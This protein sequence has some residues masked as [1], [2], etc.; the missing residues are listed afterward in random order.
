MRDRTRRTPWPRASGPS[1]RTTGAVPACMASACGCVPVPAG[2]LWPTGAVR[3]VARSLPD[4]NVR[5]FGVASRTQPHEAIIGVRRDG[6]VWDA[7]GTARRRHLSA[8]RASPRRECRSAGGTDRCQI[9]GICSRPPSGLTAVASRGSQR[10]ERS[11]R[12]R[13]VGDSGAAG[14]SASAVGAAGGATAPRSAERL[15]A[16][17]IGPVR[18]LAP[19]RAALTQTGRAGVRGL[20][21]VIQ[22]YRSMVSPLRPATCRFMPTCSQYAVEALTAYGLTRGSWL[23]AVR[24]A[25]CGP[26]HPGGWDP[27]PERHRSRVT[28]GNDAPSSEPPSGPRIQATG[29]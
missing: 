4:R 22:L 17:G 18:R 1:S 11:R 13:P 29:E 12:V 8:P 25:K 3:A 23:A 28:V 9:G 14:Q 27:I 21:F 24:L 16:G 7:L 26:W 19:L 2:R 6:E 10:V 5:L 15:P 20:V